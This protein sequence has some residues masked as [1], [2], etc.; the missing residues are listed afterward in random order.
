MSL[1]LIYLLSFFASPISSVS[2]YKEKEIVTKMNATANFLRLE[3]IIVAPEN[4]SYIKLLLVD[5]YFI[6]ANVSTE[7][8]K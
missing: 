5:H 4:C 6:E 7:L 2:G 3:S 1:N 8:K